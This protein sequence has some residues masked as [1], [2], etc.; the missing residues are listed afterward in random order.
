MKEYKLMKTCLRYVVPFSFDVKKHSFVELCESV[1]RQKETDEKGKE[2]AVWEKN[3]LKEHGPE[4]DL[5]TYV[6]KEFLFDSEDSGFDE[7]HLGYSWNHWRSKKNRD[8]ESFL[9]QIQYELGQKVFCE[10]KMIRAGVYL[11]RTGLGLFWYEIE[12]PRELADSSDLMHFQNDFREL[13]RAKKFRKNGEPFA[14]G[15]WIA[16]LFSFLPVHFLAERW[17]QTDTEEGRRMSG[18][19]QMVPDKALLFSYVCM[20][21]EGEVTDHER[22]QLAFYLANGYKESFV[23]SGENDDKMKHP[24]GTT[25]WY[26]TQEGAAYLAWPTEANRRSFTGTIFSKFKVDYFTLYIKILYQSFSLLI[27]AERI[28]SEISAEYTSYAVNTIHDSENRNKIEKASDLITEINLFLTKS[29]ATS[30]SHLH[31]Q[32]E[33]Y[34]YLKEQFNVVEDVRSVMSGLKAMDLI[35]ARTAEQEAKEQ[36]RKAEAEEKRRDDHIQAGVGLFSVLAIGSAL[37]DTFD[38]VLKFKQG[39]EGGWQTLLDS[40]AI[41]TAEILVTLAIFVVGGIAVRF[42]WKAFQE[43]REDRDMGKDG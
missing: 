33:F 30:V 35:L 43:T 21:D 6:K 19:H 39:E 41:F 9:L 24:F 38:F 11:F 36:E 40:P 10:I 8:D 5:Y 18:R 20:E 17:P 28:Q 2:H 29:M 1:E 13:N 7:E 32:N 16:K 15:T 4:S 34:C 14:L 25:L 31:N 27:Y 12:R 37:I 23:Y 3:Y 22:E 42:A 26:A